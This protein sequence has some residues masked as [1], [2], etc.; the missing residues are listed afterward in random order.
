[1]A[2]PLLTAYGG[3]GPFVFVS[4]SHADRELV[5]PELARLKEAGFNVWFDRGLNPGSR[6]TDEL[7]ER[8]SDASLFLYFVTPNSVASENCRNELQFAIGQSVD[9]LAVHLAKTALPKGLELELGARQAILKYDLAENEYARNLIRSVAS[10]VGR[11]REAAF[12]RSARYRFGPFE[13][14]PAE[15]RLTR[16]G[17]PVQ[18]QPKTFD[19]LA[20]LVVRSGRLFDKQ[21][22]LDQVWKGTVVTESSLTRGIRQIRVALDDD[23]ERSRYVETVQRTGYRFIA[24]VEEFVQPV[25]GTRTAPAAPSKSGA[26]RRAGML[27]GIGT[28]VVAIGALLLAQMMRES[29]SPEIRVASPGEQR[30]IAVLPFADL[31][32]EGDQQYFSD[33]IA[34]EVLNVLARFN[35]LRVISRSSSFA[36]RDAGLST[37]ELAEKLNVG[38]L[39]EGSVRKAGD[40]VRITAQ[41]IEARSDTHVWSET[42]DRTLDDIFAIQDEISAQ[43]VRELKLRLLDTPAVPGTTDMRVYDLYLHGLSLLARREDLPQAIESFEEVIAIDPDYAPGHASLALALI[44]GIDDQVV[45]E[46]RIEAAANNAL[47]LDPDNSDA[48]IALGFLRDYEGNIAKARAMYERAIASNPNNAMAYRWLGR[49]Y[50]SADATRYYALAHKAYLLDPLDPTIRFHVSGALARLGRYDE[51]LAVSEEGLAMDPSDFFPYAQAGYIHFLAGD[52]DK[53]LKSTYIAYRRSTQSVRDLPRVLTMLDELALAEAWV[54]EWRKLEP[55]YS[56]PMTQEAILAELRGEHDRAMEMIPRLRKRLRDR[57]DAGN[58]ADALVLISGDFNAARAVLESALREPD[59]EKIRFDPDQELS[60]SVDYVLALQ[61]TG[62]PEMAAEMSEAILT[63]LRG[64][65]AEGVVSGRHGDLHFWMAS[66]HAMTGDTDAALAELRRVGRPGG[67]LCTP[68]LRRWPH[69]DDLRGDA[70]FEALVAE[71]E[72]RYAAQRQRLADEHMLLTPQQVLQ[73]DDYSF[74]AFVRD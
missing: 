2:E 7:A 6:W 12:P 42:Y 19:L 46:P 44:W 33:G 49:T 34:E 18:L 58:L 43:V 55:D 65:L 9:V 24:P 68:C 28:I 5:Y 47:A 60:S 71:H 51:A 11:S 66:L 31:S 27:L 48:L 67:M 8:I 16:D 61:R 62:S 74:D 50:V 63:H 37:P 36:L 20:Y 59:Q 56:E 70:T 1:M 64:A 45:A 73:L 14:D 69:F 40:R 15:R 35:D 3:D 23:A 57:F 54:H 22:L 29:A 10:T 13:L 39:L 25:A 41:L 30:S 38:Y 32:P 17:D 4:Y 72:A 21:T 53:A 26:R 52:L